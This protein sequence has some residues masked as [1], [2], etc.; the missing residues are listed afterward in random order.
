MA[1]KVTPRA[2]SAPTVATAAEVDAYMAKAMA[3]PLARLIFAVDATASREAVWA[4]SRQLM[5]E[6]RRQQ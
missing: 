1:N 6:M 3:T 5:K 4:Q 2:D